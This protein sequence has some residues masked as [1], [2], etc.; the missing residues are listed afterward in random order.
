MWG[1]G[2]ACT[3]MH[4]KGCRAFVRQ[5]NQD[6]IS[7]TPVQQHGPK[8]GAHAGCPGR[9]WSGSWAWPCPAGRHPRWR[10]SARSAASA[11]RTAC[12]R[13][14]LPPADQARGR[15]PSRKQ[16]QCGLSRSQSDCGHGV[17][18]T[19]EGTS[20]AVARRSTSVPLSRHCMLSLLDMFR[21]GT[22]D[23]D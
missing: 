22:C 9:I 10:T 7:G 1:P 5:L 15:Y 17:D 18:V 3:R 8:E 13:P 12:R 23:G 2:S 16:C 21:R 14:T 11:L 6:L 19:G 20:C 4:G